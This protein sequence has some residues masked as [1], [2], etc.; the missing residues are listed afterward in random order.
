MNFFPTGLVYQFLK[1]RT[2][3]KHSSYKVAISLRLCYLYL[4]DSSFQKSSNLTLLFVF[5]QHLYVGCKTMLDLVNSTKRSFAA[6]FRC[7]IEERGVNLVTFEMRGGNNFRKTY[8]RG[9]L[10]ELN[11]RLRGGANFLTPCTPTKVTCLITLLGLFKLPNESFFG[12]L[13]VHGKN[14]EKPTCFHTI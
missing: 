13:L 10:K 1:N 5:T 7:E 12:G 8:L 14:I 4:T 6:L 3:S 9:V 11:A 2:A